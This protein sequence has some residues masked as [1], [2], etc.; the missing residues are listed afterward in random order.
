MQISKYIQLNNQIKAQNVY[1]S[2]NNI[3]R[4]KCNI[5]ISVPYDTVQFC[6]LPSYDSSYFTIAPSVN[7]TM[8]LL[9]K[10][11]SR[12]LYPSLRCHTQTDRQMHR[13]A[14]I[15]TSSSRYFPSLY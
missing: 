14:T 5:N 9:I 7:R 13:Y 11:C 4:Q 12:H 2:I 6:S 15:Y 8:D 3:L 1:K 10:Q